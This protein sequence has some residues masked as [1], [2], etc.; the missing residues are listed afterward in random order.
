MFCI[1]YIFVH[2]FF[3]YLIQPGKPA[4]RKFQ[5]RE[6]TR[7]DSL[8]NQYK[9]KLMGKSNTK[10]AVKKSKWFSSWDK[11]HV[12]VFQNSQRMELNALAPLSFYKNWGKNKSVD[13]VTLCF[14]QYL[15]VFWNKRNPWQVSYLLLVLYR[16][17]FFF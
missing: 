17:F 12:K 4:K 11:E 14:L 10:T 1:D 3:V 9:N 7:F 2:V 13:I 6:D 8:V 15:D 5:N 16:F